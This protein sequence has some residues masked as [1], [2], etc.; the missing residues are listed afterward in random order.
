MPAKKSDS[1]RTFSSTAVHMGHIFALRPR[2]ETSFGTGDFQDAK[3][4]LSEEAYD[5]AETAAR[6]VAQKALELT[7]KGGAKKGR[8]GTR[9]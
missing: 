4:F 9:R 3:Q 6:A 7:H 1:K 8:R 5:D 2:V